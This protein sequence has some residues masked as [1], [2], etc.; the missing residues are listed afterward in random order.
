M[1]LLASSVDNWRALSYDTDRPLTNR[2]A[3]SSR[4]C[5]VTVDQDKEGGLL[6]VHDCVLPIQILSTSLNTLNTSNCVI[7]D[8]AVLILSSPCCLAV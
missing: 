2:L 8:A 4:F 5:Y 6:H 3:M 1:V 7:D